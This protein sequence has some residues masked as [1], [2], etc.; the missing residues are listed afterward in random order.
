MFYENKSSGCVLQV[1]RACAKSFRS[2]RS[3]CGF[4]WRCFQVRLASLHPPRKIVRL[5][6]KL[7]S[8]SGNG[9]SKTPCAKWP[10]KLK[11]RR[12]KKDRSAN[13]GIAFLRKRAPL[14][15]LFSALE[16][17]G[18]SA[19]ESPSPQH[20]TWR[21]MEGD[22]AVCCCHPA[23]HCGG[24]YFA[25]GGANG[26]AIDSAKNR[27]GTGG[28]NFARQFHAANRAGENDGDGVD[29]PLG[30]SCDT[31]V[32]RATAERLENLPAEKLLNKLSALRLNSRAEN[33]I[34]DAKNADLTASIVAGPRATW[35]MAHEALVKTNNG[36]PAPDCVLAAE[37]F[38]GDAFDPRWPHIGP[39]RVS[40]DKALLGAFKI[41]GPLS[42]EDREFVQEIIDLSCSLRETIELRVS[43][44]DTRN[45]QQTSD[46]AIDREANDS[47]S[48]DRRNA[49]ASRGEALRRLAM[50]SLAGSPPSH[51]RPRI[52][53][54]G[55]R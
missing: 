25:R 27:L 41:N 21:P 35:E 30:R 47:R 22:L 26:Q 50:K 42:P 7:C 34:R 45:K 39:E 20:M 6:K 3:L 53:R 52:Q 43:M 15:E 10:K 23:S 14:R 37:A 46:S 36:K 18:I 12:W 17:C 49:K 55:Q 29:E 48:Q 28:R 16:Y 38:I 33:A 44:Q 24:Q 11:R 51:N 5:T 31:I 9:R 8:R 2:R 19:A 54:F 13:D 4:W 1:L 32:L 40:F